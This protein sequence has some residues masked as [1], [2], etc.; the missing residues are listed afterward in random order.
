MAA[1]TPR[2]EGTGPASRLRNE[3]EA[4]ILP[5]GRVS[6]GV[7]LTML[8]P[9]AVGAAQGRPNDVSAFVLGAA[10]A[11]TA[12]TLASRR[13]GG[14]SRLTWSRGLVTVAAGWVVAA[15]VAAVPLALSGHYTGY[16]DA[17]VEA[18]SGLTTTGLTL[19]QDLDHLP[20]AVNLW[21]HLLHLLGGQATIVVAL[22][23]FSTAG[24]PPGTL[25]VGGTRRERIVGDLR[26]AV[27]TVL[28]IASGFAVAGVG[29]L[30]LAGLAAGLRP[31][32]AAWHAVTL[33]ASAYDTGAFAATSASV[34]L[35]HSPA[36][37]AVVVVL[38][39]A[40][41]TSVAL[42]VA[43]RRGK[44]REATRQLESR[45]LAGSL[46]V[47]GLS[48]LV[49]L[50]RTGVFTEAGALARKGVFMLI[51]AHTTTGLRV[52]DGRMLLSDWGVIAPA[53]LVAAMAVGGMAASS[54][55]G[56]GTFRVGVMLKAVLRD[57][58]AVL[59]PRSSLVVCSYHHLRRR[60][61]DDAHIRM[62]TGVLLLYLAAF[63][64]GGLVT[65]ALVGGVDFTTA[66]FEAT[67]AISTTGLGVGVV[68]PSMPGL[69][70]G[71]TFVEMWLGRLQFMAVFA[72][73]AFVARLPAHVSTGPRARDGRRA[74]QDAAP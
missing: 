68:D 16:G 56:I 19:V 6:T 1:H 28:R 65:V 33:F 20:A 14:T 43:L 59:L 25:S 46:L 41:A 5:L 66:M 8:V 49:G 45:V 27:L 12:G 62:A 70:K 32:R 35:L 64:A 51:S 31:G 2:A 47:T 30:V 22:T 53:V 60:V 11:V 44:L 39:L 50:A 26:G 38:M 69:L 61:L 48:L 63:I 74:N 15:T 54:A 18:M 40:G 55:G 29:A 36:V 58:R 9:A 13:G 72:L 71:A 73:L 67:A 52:V 37:E 4:V 21:R 3:L 42:H 24:L 34:A 57:V 7:G 10:L 23:L 17:L